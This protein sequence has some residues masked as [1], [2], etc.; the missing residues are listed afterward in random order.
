MTKVSP[1]CGGHVRRRDEKVSK[2]P[3]NPA[4]PGGTPVIY[5]GS[6]NVRV[7]GKTTGLV[8][9]ASDHRRHLRVFPDDVDSI[10]TRPGFI[11]RP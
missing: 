10:L 7:T 6:G 4:V 2:L 9:Y 11:L 1:C 3:A 8:Y 5:I